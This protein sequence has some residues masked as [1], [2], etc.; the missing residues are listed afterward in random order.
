[1]HTIS[2]SWSTP[3]NPAW[4]P[5]SLCNLFRRNAVTFLCL[6]RAL[7]IFCLVFSHWL[8]CLTP[9][10]FSFHKTRTYLPQKVVGRIALCINNAWSGEPRGQHIVG[11]Q[12]LSLPFLVS[13]EQRSY[14]PFCPLGWIDSQYVFL[15]QGESLSLGAVGIWIV[16]TRGLR[17]DEWGC[18]PEGGPEHFC[19]KEPSWLG[20]WEPGGEERRGLQDAV[21]RQQPHLAVGQSSSCHTRP[22]G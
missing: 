2:C 11:A 21:W 6:S 1:M 13:H 14:L 19:G 3:R 8:S 20:S 4:L 18:G 7:K 9:L 10:N 16:E 17:W 12:E 22:A 15:M 5:P